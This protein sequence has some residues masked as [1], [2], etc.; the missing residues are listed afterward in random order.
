MPQFSMCKY[1]LGDTPCLFC[2]AINDSDNVPPN[3]QI[4]TMNSSG[5]PCRYFRHLLAIMII[6]S[7]CCSVMVRIRGFAFHSFSALVQFQ[8]YALLLHT[9]SR[10]ANHAFSQKMWHCTPNVQMALMRKVLQ[11]LKPNFCPL[12]HRLPL[13]SRNASSLTPC[14]SRE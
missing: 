5:R 10:Y 13:R 2:L 14:A 7:G 11:T 8:N 3:L 12:L 6:P 1:V 9:P 4:S